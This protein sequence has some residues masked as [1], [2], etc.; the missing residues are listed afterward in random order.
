LTVPAVVENTIV[1]GNDTPSCSGLSIV[2]SHD[3]SFPDTSCPGAN[4]DPLLEALAPN[5][6]P[7]DTQALGPGSPALDAVP[8]SGANCAQTD[9]RGVIRPAGPGC[10]VGA[11]ERSGPAVTTG[12]ATGVSSRAATLTGQVIPNGRA[13]T[14]HFE[15]GQT[16]AYGSSTPDQG[17]GSGVDPVAVSAGVDGLA[18]A[19]TYHYRL[20]AA[21]SDGTTAG[22]D[23]TFVTS[24]S[25]APVFLSAKLTRRVFKVD[26][27]GK[28]EKPVAGAKRGTAFRYT[29]SEA[30]RVVFEIERVA[31]GRK[32]GRRC[33][34]PSRAN[35]RKR[36]CKRYVSPRRFAA[37][38]KAGRNTKKFSGKIGRRALRPGRYR[39]T[40][41]ATDADGNASRPKRLAFRV[42]RR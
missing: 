41:V 17:A 37:A 26:P 13:T 19:T 29:L 21:S 4:V 8:A 22:A 36:A 12:D 1:S 20:V 10:D 6:G 34:K 9:Q 40:L 14:Y 32:V 33:R 24:R 11:F 23:R 25:D 30:A 27:R 42:V 15:F 35:S 16:A 38:A 3:I 18:R 28:A 5:G 31:P 2:D 7:T 39:A